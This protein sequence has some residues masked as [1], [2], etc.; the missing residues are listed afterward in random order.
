MVVYHV[1]G[2]YISSQC[3]GWLLLLSAVVLL[4]CRPAARDCVNPLIASSLV[5][6]RFLSLH[7]SHTSRVGSVN[8]LFAARCSPAIQYCIVLFPVWERNPV[9]IASLPDKAWPVKPMLLC[10]IRGL[11]DEVL[12]RICVPVLPSFPQRT[13]HAIQNAV[14]AVKVTG[15]QTTGYRY[16]A[17]NL[18]SQFLP[19][20][21]QFPFAIVPAGRPDAHAPCL[22]QAYM[23]KGQ[24]SSRH[25]IIRCASLQVVAGKP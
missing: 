22:P 13:T 9:H 10:G 6:A 17:V 8:A 15:T 25:S 23:M 24:V 1:V 2:H 11:P 4:S 5:L 7:W 19:R 16:A 14:C 21:S 3:C 12:N 20:H 18:C